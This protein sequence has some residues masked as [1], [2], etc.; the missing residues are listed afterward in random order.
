MF[1]TVREFVTNDP[2][3]T[4]NGQVNTEYKSL[5]NFMILRATRPASAIA[6]VLQISCVWKSIPA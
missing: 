4:A 6:S 2:K 1:N 3:I 5:D